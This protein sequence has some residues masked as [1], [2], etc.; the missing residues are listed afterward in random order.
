[1]RVIQFDQKTDSTAM[2]LIRRGVHHRE[3]WVKA[4][5]IDGEWKL[6]GRR[7][8]DQ[9]MQCIERDLRKLTKIND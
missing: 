9:V 1:M 6:N 3:N 8:H 5:K 4:E 7:I 2:V